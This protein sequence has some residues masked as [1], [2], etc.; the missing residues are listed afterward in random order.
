M[1]ERGEGDV[2]GLNYFLHQSSATK[3]RLHAFLKHLNNNVDE[4]DT[5][6]QLAAMA[7]H[8]GPCLGQPGPTKPSILMG[9]GWAL[10]VVLRAGLARLNTH[11]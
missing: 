6:E 11:L 7:H 3:S 5:K 1:R 10:F 9:H 2:P 8:V 4:Y